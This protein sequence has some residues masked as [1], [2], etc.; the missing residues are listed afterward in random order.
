MSHGEVRF[1]KA[2]TQNKISFHVEI[3]ERHKK[4]FP[5]I[6]KSKEFSSFFPHLLLQKKEKTKE[7]AKLSSNMLFVVFNAKGEYNRLV[8]SCLKNLPHQ[9]ETDTQMIPKIEVIQ[10]VNDVVRSISVFLAKLIKNANFNERLMMEAL[11]VS[12]YFDCDIL[13][14]FMVQCT[15]HLSET[16][17]SDNFQDLIS[18]ADVI[19]EIKDAKESNKEKFC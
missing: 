6:N 7:L 17:F 19:T 14:C 13:I 3:N 4:A 1:V 10:H 2:Q 18:I 15:N 11:F 12:N 9:F 5:S 8:W 16:T